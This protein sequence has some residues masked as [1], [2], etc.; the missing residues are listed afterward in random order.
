MDEH[1]DRTEE[2]VSGVSP[3]EA[4]LLASGQKLLITAPVDPGPAARNRIRSRSMGVTRAA[5][6][7]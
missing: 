6:A 2:D 3:A 4:E 1:R 7:R 5:P